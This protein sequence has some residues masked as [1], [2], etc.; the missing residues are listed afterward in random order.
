MVTNLGP[1]HSSLTSELITLT[2]RRW[3]LHAGYSETTKRSH[4]QPS[5]S[6]FL[7]V[8]PW[9]S[10]YPCD[11]EG[12]ICLGS[13]TCTYSLL[14]NPFLFTR[15][16]VAGKKKDYSTASQGEEKRKDPR[17]KKGKRKYCFWMKKL[18]SPGH[19]RPK[20]VNAETLTAPLESSLGCVARRRTH[21]HLFIASICC[22]ELQMMN[23]LAGL[24]S[25]VCWEERAGGGSAEAL[26][27]VQ[28]Q[29]A[30]FSWPA[31]C[32]SWVLCGASG[33]RNNS[34]VKSHFGIQQSYLCPARF[35]VQWKKGMNR[36]TNLLVPFL[37]GESYK[38]FCP[39]MSVFH[40]LIFFPQIENSV[41]ES[42]F[43]QSLSS[44]S[45]VNSTDMFIYPHKI[46]SFLKLLFLI[47]RACQ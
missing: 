4:F 46:L 39:C 6:A 33:A 41:F 43:W 26:I 11:Q 9:T 42:W 27:P 16:N 5:C 10:H 8:M 13:L 21:D 1:C 14:L 17:R 18:M 23:F 32:T 45:Y 30:A 3:K 35:Q 29:A 38:L 24:N 20:W 28:S 2:I 25:S 40:A 44:S 37:S 19:G 36:W 7:V 47:T 34:H 22:P 31:P 12:M 15:E